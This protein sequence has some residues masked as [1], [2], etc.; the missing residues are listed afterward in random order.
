MLNELFVAINIHLFI[1]LFKFTTFFHHLKLQK[2]PDPK[3]LISDPEHCLFCVVQIS[4]FLTGIY[5]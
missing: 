1:Y 3:L 4:I 2:D 5:F